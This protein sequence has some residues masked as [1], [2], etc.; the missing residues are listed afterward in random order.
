M[1]NQQWYHEDTKVQGWEI[2]VEIGDTAHNEEW[3]IVK[4]PSNK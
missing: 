3:Q 1:V 4:E 2:M